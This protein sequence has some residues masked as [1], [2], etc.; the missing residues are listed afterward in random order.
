MRS[1]FQGVLIFLL[2]AVPVISAQDGTVPLEPFT[3]DTY[4]LQGVIPEGWE[5]AGPGLYARGSS[6]TDFTLVAV[7]AAPVSLEELWTALLPQLGLSDAPESVGTYEGSAFEF[8][9]YQVDVSAGGTDVQVDVA[10]S[11]HEGQTI[12]VLL[13][14]NPDEYEQLH[15]EVFLPMLAALAPF[16]VTEDLPYHV[17]E[18]TFTNGDA[19]LAGTLTIPQGEGQHPGVVLMTGSGPQNRDEMVVPGFPIFRLI[20]DYLTRQGIAV[21]RYDDRGI[22]QS[23]GEWGETSLH[24]FASDGQ[25]AVD[26]LLTRDDI[27][28]A[29]VGLLGHSEGGY[30]AAIIGAIPDSNVAFIILMAGPAVSGTDVLLVQNED[31]FAQAGASPE[32]IQAQLDFL[33]ALFPLLQARDYETIREL[34]YE[35][36]LEQWDTLTEDERAA[37]GAEDAES[38]AKTAA[39]NM[40]AQVGNEPFAS[41]IEYDPAADLA[42]IDVP[43]LA[44]YGGLDIQV[45][46][47]A[48][49]AALEGIVAGSGNADVTIITLE[50]AN[51]LFQAAKTGAIEEYSELDFEFTA[52]FLPTVSDWILDRVDVV[53]E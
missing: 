36:A 26:Y 14:T 29:Q 35:T 42:A 20:A 10:M 37:T 40:L 31:I 18:V 32:D 52:D 51:H 49:V 27:N 39:D 34:A 16:E 15:E 45:S 24:E 50:D 9:L 4:G 1:I 3:D 33:N 8:V 22:G 41:L 25:A 5:S 30:Y 6:S 44:I 12:V 43:L 7:Q 48:N 2:M 53:A 46:A 23:S 17:E 21:L 47:E 11:E 38:F 28:P 19:K 13:Q